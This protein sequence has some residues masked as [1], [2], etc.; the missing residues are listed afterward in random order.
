MLQEVYGDEA[1]SRSRVFDWHRRFKEGREDLD[2]DPRAGRPSTSK[3]EEN[4]E[5]VRQVVRGD[6][7]LTVRMIADEVG[8]NHNA[9]WE[10]ITEDLGMRKICAKMV[11]KLL[12]NDQKDR[13]KQVCQDII[14]RLE[15][16]PDLLRRVI[17]G[18]ETWVFEYDPETKRQSLQWKSRGS[19]RPKKARQSKSKTKVMLII[20]FDV[21]GI[22]H[23]EFI[24]EGQTVNQ[25]VYKG[26]LQRLLRSVRDK[27]REL[28]ENNSW[29]LHH[30]NA[31]AHTALSIREFL[32]E[33]NVTVMEQPPYSPDLAPC[34]FFLFPK[35][36]RIIKGTRFPDVEA[37]KTD[38]TA[39]LRVIPG[40][41]FWK[42]VEAWQG[43]LEKCVRQEGDYFEGDNL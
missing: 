29:L 12:S 22:V 9:V 6:R 35:L 38:V 23:M 14:E 16:D 37:I 18:D 25:H 36:K 40:D 24:P 30:D 3:T 34:D 8:M 28:W 13:R 7:R 4:V 39:E 19:P 33:K 43:R 27:R 31:P 41:D 26:I 1:M 42:C 21:R 17:T 10:I 20:F 2:D 15:T 32:A 11:P 5:R